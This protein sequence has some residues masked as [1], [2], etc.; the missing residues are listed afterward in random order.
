MERSSYKK[1][2][3]N[4]EDQPSPSTIWR[5]RKLKRKLESQNNEDELCENEISHLLPEGDSLNLEQDHDTCG[6]T[7]KFNQF[8]T[9]NANVRESITSENG[10]NS[11]SFDAIP[12]LG[13]LR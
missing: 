11:W 9:S 5:R 2:I 7:T 12:C 4:A 3:F 1:W 6:T 13:K 10:D 8:E